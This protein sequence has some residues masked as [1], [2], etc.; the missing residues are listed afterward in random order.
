M[1]P[2]RSQ[3][4][5]SWLIT[6]SPWP[7]RFAPPPT[8]KVPASLQYTDSLASAFFSFIVNLANA[9]QYHVFLP[10]LDVETHVRGSFKYLY[11]ERQNLRTSNEG[12]PGRLTIFTLGNY[13]LFLAYAASPVPTISMPRRCGI[14]IK[15]RVCV[16]SRG[17]VGAML[18]SLVNATLPETTHSILRV[19]RLPPLPVPTLVLR[20]VLRQRIAV[21]RRIINLIF[22]N[23]YAREWVQQR[24]RITVGKPV[25][26][27]PVSASREI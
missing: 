12:Q 6:V 14:P 2:C 18:Y 26:R 9:A 4:A 23:S 13:A 8:Q 22:R 7:G 3:V 24:L 17:F 10:K 27:H 20:P 19:W 1:Q 5:D 21:V 25:A 11:Q 15:A 16:R